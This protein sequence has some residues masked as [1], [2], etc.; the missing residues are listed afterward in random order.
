MQEQGWPHTVL[1]GVTHPCEGSEQAGRSV[2][3]LTEFEVH[4]CVLSGH[5][6]AHLYTFVDVGNLGT[7]GSLGR[8]DRL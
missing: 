6:P 8:L 4:G 7:G 3:F 2:P 1:Y 5:Y